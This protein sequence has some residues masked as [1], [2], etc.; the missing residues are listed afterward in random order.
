MP[1]DSIFGNPATAHVSSDTAMTVREL[2]L[3]VTE[4]AFFFPLVFKV[5]VRNGAKIQTTYSIHLS[6]KL[7]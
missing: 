6:L 2:A 3:K 5:G 1:E 7:H 4:R